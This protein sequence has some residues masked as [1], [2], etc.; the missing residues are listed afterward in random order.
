[1][2][3]NQRDGVNAFSPSFSLWNTQLTRVFSK[4]FEIYFGGENIGNYKQSSPIIGSEDPFGINFDASQVYAPVFGGIVY[5]GLR[6]K[7]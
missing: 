4:K 6:L 3:K 5:S 1:L 2:V 7:I